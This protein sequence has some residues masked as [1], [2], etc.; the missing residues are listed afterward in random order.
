[1]VDAALVVVVVVAVDRVVVVV[2]VMVQPTVACAINVNVV[3]TKR[4]KAKIDMRPNKN[5]A[6]ASRGKK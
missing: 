4:Y 2:V 1:M 6:T 5:N 3:E